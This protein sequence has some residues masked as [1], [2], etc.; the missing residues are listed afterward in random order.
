M[1]L[2]EISQGIVKN[3]YE[4]NSLSRMLQG[5]P[6]NEAN[7]LLHESVLLLFTSCS[8]ADLSVA[9]SSP[10]SVHKPASIFLKSKALL[11]VFYGLFHLAVAVQNHSLL[12]DLCPSR[13]DSLQELPSENG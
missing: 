2:N 12:Q 8:V 4:F 5:E 6:R 10:D 11:S 1:I 7:V 3:P 13:G 9:L